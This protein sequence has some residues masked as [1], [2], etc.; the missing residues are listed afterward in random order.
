MKLIIMT[1]TSKFW[2][3]VGFE[4]QLVMSTCDIN[5]HKKIGQKTWNQLKINTEAKIKM[6]NT[7]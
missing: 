6:Y 4:N 1:L 3:D 5:C 2:R 7:T